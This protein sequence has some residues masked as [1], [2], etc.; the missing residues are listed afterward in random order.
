MTGGAGFI[1]R[2]LIR[3][4]ADRGDVVLGLDLAAAERSSPGM[5][6]RR[7]DIL[8]ASAL[9]RDVAAFGP[10]AVV[11]LAARTDLDERESLAGYAANTEGTANL[12]AAVRRTPGVARCLFTSSQAVCRAGWAPLGDTDYC[13]ATLYGQSKARMEEI[14]RSED[15]GGVVWC[16]LRP[17]TIWG[18]GLAGHYR[19]LFRLIA[20]GLYRHIGPRPLFK[21]YG[22]VENTVAQFVRLLDAPAETVH[23]RTLYLADY[24]PISLRAWTE[25]FARALG[26]PP[27]RTMPEPAAR[28]IARLGDGVEKLGIGRPW[29]TSFRL[30]NILTEYRFDLSETERICGPLPFGMEQGVGRTVAWLRESGVLAGAA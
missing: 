1:G 27:I 10:D 2:H 26:A 14:V 18:P 28:L 6:Q 16:L 15:C 3:A 24:E 13:P 30:N 23:R 7:R 17:T 8:D 29:L 25:A 19:R 11:H 12:I 22:Y 21:S 9:S 20:R 4:L 5:T